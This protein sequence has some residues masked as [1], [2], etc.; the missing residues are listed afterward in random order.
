MHVGFNEGK[1][2]DAILRRIEA[3]MRARRQN[4]R[5]PENERHSAAVE[6]VCEI[7]GKHFALEHTG[8]EPFEGYV[9]LQ[10]DA[11]THFRPLEARISDTLPPTEYIELHMPLKATEGLRGKALVAAQSAIA[12]YVLA[13]APTL[14]VARDGRYVLPIVRE[15][16]PGVAFEVSLHKWRRS[17]QSIGFRIVQTISEDLEAG[18]RARILRACEKKFPKLAAW[19]THGATSILVLEDNDIQTTGSHLVAE[20]F[21]QVEQSVPGA[22][23]DEV[24]LVDTFSN[25]WWAHVIRVGTKTFFDFEDHHGRSWEIEPATLIDVTRDF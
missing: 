15:N 22:R 9:R 5:W 12:E 11:L 24:Y 16:P 13:K 14:P 10:N 6:L 21:L 2:C 4:C 8:V 17:W 3:S 7:G 19:Q 18:R 23:P 25:T 1:A 20:A